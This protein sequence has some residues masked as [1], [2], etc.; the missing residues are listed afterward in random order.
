MKLAIIRDEILLL[1]SLITLLGIV[2]KV[3]NNFFLDFI[4]RRYENI[5]GKQSLFDTILKSIFYVICG[6][7]FIGL[8]ISYFMGVINKTNYGSLGNVYIIFGIIVTFLFTYFIYSSVFILFDCE[9][10][11]INK[12]E[13]KITLDKNKVNKL[14]LR[15]KINMYIALFFSVTNICL[16][17]IYIIASKESILSHEDINSVITVSLIAIISITFF[18]YSYSLKTIIISLKDNY[19][20]IINTEGSEI[21]CNSY[22][23]YKEYYLIIKDNMEI[24]INKNKVKEIIKIRST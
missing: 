17:G 22:L 19:I 5:P 10:I 4:K 21:Y 8:I 20:Y 12:L 15:N 24:Y 11:F 1:T 2:I 6:V 3:I 23:E 16:I 7:E 13:N 14:N 18:I 9:K